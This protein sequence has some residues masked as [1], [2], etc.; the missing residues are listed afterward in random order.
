VSQDPAFWSTSNKLL[1]DPQQLNS[2]GYAR[3]NPLSYID[4][5]GEAIELAARSLYGIG[6][7]L[8]FHITPFIGPL[9]GDEGMYQG[10]E[11]T[12]GAY[13]RDMFDM[14]Q[15]GTNPF[16]NVLVKEIGMAGNK[17]PNTDW[18]NGNTV[19]SGFARV[20][21]TPP[22]AMSE[23]EFVASLLEA[24]GLIENFQTYNFTTWFNQNSNNFIYEL[25]LRAGIGGQVSAFVNTIRG[26]GIL[27]PGGDSVTGAGGSCQNCSTTNKTGGGG[28]WGPSSVNLSAPSS[29][30]GWEGYA[31]R[32]GLK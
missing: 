5:S 14:S 12:L 31:Q 21:I 25:G 16:T 6:A 13:N 22:N 3:N 30:G 8:F 7:H 9:R 29:G 4:S 11:F 23:Q 17:A 28:S 20:A 1:T 27:V 10:R 15:A 26:A 18:E 24:F 19:K 32:R 2:Y